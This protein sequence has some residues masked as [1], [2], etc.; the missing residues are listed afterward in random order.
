MSTYIVPGTKLTSLTALSV[1]TDSDLFYVVDTTTNTSRKT[2]YESVTSNVFR[3]VNS[4]FLS[5]TGG[6]VNGRV[7]ILSG[8]SATNFFYTSGN[9]VVVPYN[10]SNFLYLCSAQTE[11]S[12]AATQQYVIDQVAVAG[13]ITTT[14]LFQNFV[15]LSGSTVTGNISSSITPTTTGEYVNLKY[16]TDN[17]IP[18]TGGT[19]TGSI[20]VPQPSVGD[21]STRVATVGYVENRIAAQPGSRLNYLSAFVVNN[22]FNIHNNSGRGN[23]GNG[24]TFIRDNDNKVRSCGLYGNTASGGYGFYQTQLYSFPQLPIEFK[25]NNGTE[26]VQ[27]VLN[28]GQTTLIL[29]NLGNI[30]S[31]GSNTAGQLGVGD[32][33]RRNTFV[34][35]T[36]SIISSTTTGISGLFISQGNDQTS[37][38]C[39]VYAISGNQLYAWGSNKAGQLGLGITT[40]VTVP[41]NVNL[42]NAGSSIDG[43]YLNRIAASNSANSGYVF[44]IDSN[45]IVH[46]AGWNGAGQLGLSASIT[47]TA[48]NRKIGTIPTGTTS[49]KTSQLWTL[50]N[51]YVSPFKLTTLPVL[52]STTI[53]AEQVYTAGSNTYLLTG[54]KVWSCGKNGLGACG[55]GNALPATG[56][57]NGIVPYWQQVIDSTGTP[58][59]GVQY[60]TTSGDPNNQ[61]NVSICAYVSALSTIKVWGSNGSGCLGTGDYINKVVATTPSSTPN[62]ILKVKMAGQQNNTTLFALDSAGDIYVTGTVD[63]GLDGRGEGNIKKQNTFQ[64]VIRPQGIKWVD[65]EVFTYG[66]M[67]QYKTVLAQSSTNE[68]YVWGYNTYNQAGFIN[69][70]T[71]KNIID[72]PIKISLF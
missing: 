44:A 57:L 61:G 38:N 37:T 2:T 47:G 20:S 51:V 65:F 54:G 67:S 9:G 33:K 48:A 68:L 60:L 29:S 36:S 28:T 69:I 70:P 62:G 34:N 46:V 42:A 41:A 39:S 63:G 25:T 5:S 21:P 4:Y 15:A 6:T 53:L 7:T 59:T 10:T 31:T 3:D 66:D 35:I 32:I 24:V 58:L 50:S 56:F 17:Y 55:N 30:Y 19:F 22:S 16:I 64:K 12:K 43:Q 49:F 26:T 23:S 40:D 72:V 52:I 18:K 45:N 11:M 8:V 1:L 27:S 14:Y 71:T 13:G